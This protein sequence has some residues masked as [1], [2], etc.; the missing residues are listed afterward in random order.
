MKST[1]PTSRTRLD[2]PELEPEKLHERAVLAVA[3]LVA[4]A[5]GRLR[6]AQALPE[7]RLRERA[8]DS[9]GIRVAREAR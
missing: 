9:V 6:D 8:R 5:D 4:V 1:R 7:V 2:L 3:Q